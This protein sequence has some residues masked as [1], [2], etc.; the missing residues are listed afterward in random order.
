MMKGAGGDQTEGPPIS[1][2]ANVQGASI[3]ARNTNAL[4]VDASSRGQPGGMQTRVNWLSGE[5]GMNEDDMFVFSC[6]LMFEN[7][8]LWQRTHGPSRNCQS[9]QSETCRRC[10]KLERVSLAVLLL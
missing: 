2:L 6:C 7:A 10:H 4:F 8:R 1:I 5:G 9:I 3:R